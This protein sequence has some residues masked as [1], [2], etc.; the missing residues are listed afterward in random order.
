[1]GN[2]SN[3]LM[4]LALGFEPDPLNT[5]RTCVETAH[6][7]LQVLEILLAG[8]G[9]RCRDP[10]MMKSPA[11]ARDCGWLFVVLSALGQ[12]DLWTKCKSCKRAPPRTP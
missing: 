10:E 4:H 7:N 11:A 1:M 8:M 6:K 12:V 3:E 9:D 5:I 2:S